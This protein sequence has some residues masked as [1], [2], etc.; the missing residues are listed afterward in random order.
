MKRLLVVSHRPLDQEGGFTTR[1]RAF[2]RYLPE[3]GWEV[4]VLSAS[5]GP[6]ASE[7]ASSPRDAHRAAMRARVMS[8]V[9]RLSGPIFAL[10]GVRPEAMP[11]S[12][13]WLPRGGLAVRRRLRGGAHDAVLATGPPMAGPL[14][15]RLGVPAG[16][17]PLLV[18]LRDLWAGSPAFDRGGGALTRVEDWL[19][20]GAA[21]V[22]VCT[23]EAAADVRRRHP[24]V[25]GRVRKLPN[26]FD[27]RLLELR[28]EADGSRA[29]PL[30]ILHSGTLVPDRPLAPLLRVLAR[31]PFRSAFRVVLQGFVAPAMANELALADGA[32]E[33]VV[34]PPVPWEEA[35]REMSAA[36][37]TLVSQ[38]RAAGDDTAVAAKVY[39]YLALGKPVL[40]LSHGG[41]TEALLRSLGADRYCARLDDERSIA[42]ALERLLAEPGRGAPTPET[43]APYDRRRLARQLAAELDRVAG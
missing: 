30:T 14:A 4:D 40:C 3:Q 25:A 11:L 16:G 8:R 28:D 38:A 19:L 20:R 18:E 2:A 24:G 1:W 12:M 34:K 21:T 15:A 37:V 5:P 42:E 6:G 35:V 23:S 31:E 7:F 26:G 27:P 13:A 36:D 29:A 32:C 22:I 41:A 43:L 17:P 10:A 33:L 9:G 39:E